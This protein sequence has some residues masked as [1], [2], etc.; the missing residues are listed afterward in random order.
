VS[1][2]FWHHVSPALSPLP[3]GSARP[4][5][6]LT[7]EA[8]VASLRCAL[9]S[10]EKPKIATAPSREPKAAPSEDLRPMDRL[11][12]IMVRLRDP[13]AGCPWDLEQDFSTIVPHTIEEA[14]EVADAIERGDM[15][16]LKGELGDL[17]FQVVFYAQM[18]REGGLFSFE[19]IVRGLNE[20]MIKRHPHVFAQAEI[21][22]AAAQT[23]AWEEQKAAE[24][25]AEAAARGEAISQLD[26]VPLG[27]PA[28]TRAIKL[29]K[30][31]ARIGFDWPEAAQ[32]LDKI[33]EEADEIKTEMANGG[34]PAR[35]ADEVGDLLFA[36]ANLARHLGLD[37]EQ[38]LR[39]AN[40]KFERR[41]R[42]LEALLAI[43]HGAGA[44]P[45]LEALEALWQRVKRE[46]R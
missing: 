25:M 34:A 16:G 27:L 35:L 1:E 20:K 22:S 18:A 33:A 37:P 42:R 15:E 17:L 30:R 41:F 26:G 8:A 24:R 4:T 40:A 44:R 39:G 5:A 7:F 13:K 28:L 12:A 6:P 14:Y 31:A 9:M 21:G 11:L 2:A 32:V 23:E 36:V 43:E 19:E 38:S 29:Q 46:E 45:G 3:T 10:A